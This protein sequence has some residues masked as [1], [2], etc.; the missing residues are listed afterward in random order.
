MWLKF[1]NAFS[2]LVDKFIFSYSDIAAYFR[3]SDKL[4]ISNK[5]LSEVLLM[6]SYI[7]KRSMV[8]S[9]KSLVPAFGGRIEIILLNIHLIQTYF[10]S[11][12]SS[13]ILQIKRNYRLIYYAF[14]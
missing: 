9:Y 11:M 5:S 8:K 4:Y 10:S 1:L 3:D 2:L 7:I 13:I 6:Y 14:P 12:L